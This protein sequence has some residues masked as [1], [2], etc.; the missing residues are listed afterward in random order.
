MALTGVHTLRVRQS[1]LAPGSWKT[2]SEAPPD[3]MHRGPKSLA[4]RTPFHLAPGCGGCQRRLP[5]GGAAKGMPL[6]ARTCSPLVTVPST[7]P[8]SVFTRSGL[9]AWTAGTRK[10]TAR[11]E[12]ERPTEDV[13][14]MDFSPPPKLITAAIEGCLFTGYNG[15]CT[16]RYVNVFLRLHISVLLST[17]SA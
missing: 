15:V 11:K 6:K 4:V 8:L 10:H 9:A 12:A 2:M 7:T 14:R 16:F 1:S 17:I 13:P 5:T 3:W